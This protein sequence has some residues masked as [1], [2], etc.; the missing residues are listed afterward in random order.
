M[1]LN[2][3]LHRQQEEKMR[4][5]AASCAQSRDSH[6]ELAE[7]YADRIRNATNGRVDIVPGYG[8]SGARV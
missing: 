7:R 2:Y 6:Q 3:L 5:E 1:D 8:M 4:A